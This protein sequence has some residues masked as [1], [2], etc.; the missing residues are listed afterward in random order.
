[1]KLINN[2][3]KNNGSSDIAVSFISLS[4][5]MNLFQVLFSNCSQNL[6]L[7]TFYFWPWGDMCECKKI[8][9]NLRAF[10]KYFSTCL[11]RKHFH[12]HMP[13]HQ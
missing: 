11:Q 4:L 1:M 5:T 9:A 12:L 2:I 13:M 6:S 7:F 3:Y 10:D 8:S